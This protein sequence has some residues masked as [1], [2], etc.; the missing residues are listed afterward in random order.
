MRARTLQDLWSHQGALIR[1]HGFPNCCRQLSQPMYIQ[2]TVSIFCH[3]L[4]TQDYTA[5]VPMEGIIHLQLPTH[6]L[7]CATCNITAVVK[8]SSSNSY[9]ILA[10]RLLHSYHEFGM[11]TVYHKRT[12]VALTFQIGIS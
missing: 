5:S 9:K 6:S 2:W 3:L 1:M 8:K 12:T 10:K 11:A 7:I 4:K